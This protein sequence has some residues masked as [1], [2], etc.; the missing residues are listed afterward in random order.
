MNKTDAGK[1]G[2]ANVFCEG[3]DG[4][5]FRLCRQAAWLCDNY[6]ALLFWCASGHTPHT[7]ECVWRGSNKA[8][9]VKALKFEFGTIF[10]CH[11]IFF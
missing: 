1:Q 2:S 8:S 4:K 3:P 10:M 6:A 11:E 9:F 5:H 7:Q